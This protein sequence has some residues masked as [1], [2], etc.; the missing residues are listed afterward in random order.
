M[1]F[2]IGFLIFGLLALGPDGDR[3]PPSLMFL[4]FL[5]TLLVWMIS[6]RVL[7]DV[8]ARAARSSPTGARPWRWRI[9]A[10]GLVLDNGLHHN[11]IDWRGVRAVLEEKDRF[12]F[13]VTPAYNPVLPSRS[14]TPEQKT[15]LRALV[16]EVTATG[17]MGTGAEGQG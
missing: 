5:T 16:A 11:R 10:D 14:L 8:A 12:L 2:P 13:L 3:F 17:R 4:A 7:M 15:A 9:D 1:V 6:N